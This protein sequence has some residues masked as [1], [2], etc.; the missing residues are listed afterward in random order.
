M[1][2]SYY[3][4]KQRLVLLNTLIAVRPFTVSPTKS[5]TAFFGG[6]ITN[7]WT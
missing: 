3:R 6:I 4:V 1:A 7:R 2:L 5:D